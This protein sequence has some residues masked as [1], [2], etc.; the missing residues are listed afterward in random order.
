MLTVTGLSSIS[1]G[2]G[3][4]QINISVEGRKRAIK[5][6]RKVCGQQLEAQLSGVGYA[7]SLTCHREDHGQW[8]EDRDGD[9]C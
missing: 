6:Q 9:A 7:E 8:D 4:R 5:I 2:D 1:V 3:N